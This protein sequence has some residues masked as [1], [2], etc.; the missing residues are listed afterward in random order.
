M[1]THVCEWMCKHVRALKD[2]VVVAELHG[3]FTFVNPV[4]D[5]AI[6]M[7]KSVL[8]DEVVMDTRYGGPGPLPVDRQGVP[9]KPGDIYSEGF[10]VRRRPDGTWEQRRVTGWVPWPSEDT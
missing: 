3:S 7:T 10:H 5:F 8:V 6:A 9:H 1:C 2:G 4:W